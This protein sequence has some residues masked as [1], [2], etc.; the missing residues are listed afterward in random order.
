VTSRRG[1]GG[2]LPRAFYA[3]HATSVARALLGMT[4]LRDG[5]GGIIV[6]TEAYHEDEPA[7]H[8]FV[9]ETRRNRSLFLEGGHLYVYRIH[10]VVCANVSCGP[11]GL[12]AGVLLRALLPTDGLETIA[13]RRAGAPRRAWTD[14][15]GKLC[16]ALAITLEDDGQDLLAARGRVRVVDR[17]ERARD[18]QVVTGPRVGI[19][20]AVDLPWRFRYSPSSP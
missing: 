16:R 2:D 19:S 3:G 18:E 6:E 12:G 8:A 14:G 15:P 10:Q 5:V 7:S 4:L 1:R 13:L 20:K 11:A 9:G 17:G